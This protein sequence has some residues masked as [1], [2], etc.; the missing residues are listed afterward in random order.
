MSR[1]S[2]KYINSRQAQDPRYKALRTTRSTLSMF[3]KSS[4]K[5]GKASRSRRLEAITGVSSE[6]LFQHLLGTCPNLTAENY[7]KE[8]EI[9]H[10]KPIGVFDSDKRS[11]EQVLSDAFTLK[12]LQIVE[13]QANRPGRFPLTFDPFT[14]RLSRRLYLDRE[15]VQAT[16]YL[17]RKMD[18]TYFGVHNG[19]IYPTKRLTACIQY[20][21]SKAV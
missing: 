12:N 8:Y 14:L 4:L 18:P 17:I 9:D 3:L 10:I 16:P 2:T 20:L 13:K 15:I 6:T 1:P 21:A 5:Q 11:V 19:R 7:G